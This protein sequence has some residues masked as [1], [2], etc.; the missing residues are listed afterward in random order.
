[1][2]QY[3]IISFKGTIELFLK[4]LVKVYIYTSLLENP[5]S[6]IIANISGMGPDVSC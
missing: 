6:Y 3:I 2:I 1:M 5:K 4:V